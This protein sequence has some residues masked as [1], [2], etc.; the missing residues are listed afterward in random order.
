MARTWSSSAPS[1]RISLEKKLEYLYRR[2]TIVDNL[3]NFLEEYAG[4]SDTPPALPALFR[5][6][7]YM[8]GERLA[9]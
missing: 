9:G 8:T 6:R 5:G 7:D 1:P 2:R 3:I 4:G